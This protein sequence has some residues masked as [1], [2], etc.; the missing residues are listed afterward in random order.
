MELQIGPSMFTKEMPARIVGPTEWF[1]NYKIDAMLF[2]FRDRT[3]LGRWKA[4]KVAFMSCVFSNQMK[5]SYATFQKDKTKFKVQVLLHDYGTGQLPPHGR[6]RLVWDVDVSRTYVPVFVHAE[7]KKHLNV[8]KYKVVYVTVPVINKSSSDC[9]VYALKFIECHALGLDFTLVNDDNI[10]EARQKI[11]YDLWEAANDSELMLRMS[12]YTPPKTITSDIL[13][14]TSQRRSIDGIPSRC[15][16]G[17]GIRKKEDHLFK[18]VDE[19]M[20]DELRRIDAQQALIE[21]EIDDLKKCLK[22]TGERVDVG[23]VAII[24]W[25]F[26]RVCNSD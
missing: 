1:E 26:E 23:C 17:K 12:K 10:R 22:K 7:N 16:C 2:L 20:F 4:N 8:V 5:C 13:D 15:W 3:T 21:E 18:W 14:M 25:L 24:Q 11:A 19:A 9:G 6:T